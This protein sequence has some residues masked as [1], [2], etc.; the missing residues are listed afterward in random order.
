MLTDS[1]Y[2][3]STDTYETIVLGAHYDDCG[4]PGNARAPGANDDG[5]GIGALVGIARAIARSGV[6]FR[7]HVQLI[8]FAGEEQGMVGSRVY[9]REFSSFLRCFSISTDTFSTLGEL[10]KAG[11]NITMMIQGDMLAYHA[12]GEPPQLG[13]SDPVL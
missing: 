3:A 1:T 2:A 10:K 8:A 7:K 11:A 5:S 6:V 12:D 9:V 4:S 13:L